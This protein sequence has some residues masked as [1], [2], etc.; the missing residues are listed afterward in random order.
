MGICNSKSDKQ[1]NP[2]N[3]PCSPKEIEFRYIDGRRFHNLENVVYPLPND[4]D[5]TDRLHFRHF[6]TRYIWQSNFSAPINDILNDSDTQILDVGCGA[7]SWAFDMA[8]T[9]PLIKIIGIDISQQPPT[10]IKPDNF[11]FIKANVL[12]ELPFEE[13]TFDYVFQRNLF[14]AFT[15][16]NWPDVIDELVRVLKP[17]GFI[18]LSE[19]SMLHNAGPATKRLCEAEMEAM[20]LRGTDPFTSQKLDKYLQNQGQLRNIKK[21]IRKCRHG[22][23]SNQAELN[24]SRTAINNLVNTY[25]AWKPRLAKIMKISSEEYDELAKISEKELFEYDTYYNIVR[26]YARKSL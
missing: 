22:S 26:V 1:A 7:A 9:Y 8:T 19:P 18:E 3:S 21:E 20:K 4:D 23:K 14:G 13:S 25:S 2:I 12:E 17:G 16:Q 11:T 24:L 5:E 6:L 10:Y 15:E